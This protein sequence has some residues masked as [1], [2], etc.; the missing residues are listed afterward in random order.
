MLGV[1]HFLWLTKVDRLEP[2]VYAVLLAV[3]LVARLPAF[4]WL[5][6]RTAE[7]ACE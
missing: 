5:G 4:R 6:R 3:L 2:V 7:A 1:L